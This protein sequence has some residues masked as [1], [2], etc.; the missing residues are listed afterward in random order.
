MIGV[1]AGLMVAAAGAQQPR[2]SCD[3]GHDAQ[4]SARESAGCAEERFDVA[5]QGA[6][7]VGEEQ[8]AAGLSGADGLRQQFI[9]VDEDGNGRISRDEWLRWFGPARADKAAHGQPR[10][11]H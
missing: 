8:F 1:A 2:S 4:V 6:D 7:A 9:Q 5:R 10:A 11:T 3:G